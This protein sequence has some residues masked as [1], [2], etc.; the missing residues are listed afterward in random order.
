MPYSWLEDVQSG[1]DIPE[2]GTL[3][4][5]LVKEH[6]IRLVAFA[7]DAGQELTE[8]T[9]SVPVVVQVLS[10]SLT[11]EVAGERHR[12]T[13][14]SWMLLGAGEPHSVFAD[15]PSRMLLTMIRSE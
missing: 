10:G 7:F 4:R 13:P 11:V 1:I 6:P 12:L 9:A 15:E 5:V 14:H 3:S 2:E 8:H